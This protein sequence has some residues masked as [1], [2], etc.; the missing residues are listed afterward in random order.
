[1]LNR[2][3]SLSKPVFFKSDRMSAVLSD[4]GIRQS[5]NDIL[6]MAVIVG[7]N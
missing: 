3:R 6:T 2:G 1:M 7:T 5:R 4:L